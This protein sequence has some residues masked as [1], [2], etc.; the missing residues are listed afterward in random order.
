MLMHTPDL[1]SCAFT[2]R[3]THE[4]CLNLSPHPPRQ[5]KSAVNGLLCKPNCPPS[6]SALL[7]LGMPNSSSSS[8]L[9]SSLVCTRTQQ[10]KG[11][12]SCTRN[13]AVFRSPSGFT[14]T[15]CRSLGPKYHRVPN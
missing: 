4:L 1:S 3:I 5:R 8:S 11:K 9:K 10:R 13:V 2:A 12:R 6:V 15:R 14:T 7:L